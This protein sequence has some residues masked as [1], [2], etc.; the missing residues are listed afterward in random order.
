MSKHLSRRA[1]SSSFIAVIVIGIA[2]IVFSEIPATSLPVTTA[3]ARR[4]S[5]SGYW[6]VASDG[7]IF[8][9]GD[10]AFYGSSGAIHLNRPIVGMAP[11]VNELANGLT[12]PSSGSTTTML[13][14]PGYTS[15]QSILDDHFAGTSLDPTK[16]VTY[17]GSSGTVWNNY[18][19]LPTPYSGPNVP[20]SGN[21]VAMFGPSQVSVDNGLTLT[22][23]RNTNQYAGTYPWISGVVTTEGKFSLPATGWYVQVKAR[24]PDQSRGMWP[25]IWF[26]PGA[27]GPAFN[28]IDGY[29]G[30]FVGPG[31]PN[32]LMNS[33]YFANQGQQDQLAP[34]GFD[35]SAG[36]HVYGVR[37]VPGQSIT[38][39]VDGRQ[40]YQVLASS[41]VSITSESYQIMLELQVAAQQ[42]SGWHTTVNASTPTS[43][44][45]VAEVQAYS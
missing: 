5:A 33:D 2:S 39:Y 24:M 26:L 7:G 41:G 10:A 27:P 35:S 28:E 22:A 25:A 40:V 13:P 18:G 43:T 34:L 38:A 12:T 21:E 32:T 44:M 37:Y 16:W 36:Y 6:M 8:A 15:S 42:T 1:R 14:P 19:S 4:A 17:L 3:G 9:Y 11:A 29:E 31:D 45:S 20:G 30:G 23:Q